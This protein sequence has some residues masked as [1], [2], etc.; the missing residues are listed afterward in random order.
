MAYYR[1]ELTFEQGRAGWSELYYTNADDEATLEERVA[2]LVVSRGALLEVP[3]VM[4]F[5]R[6]SEAGAPGIARSYTC[7]QGTFYPYAP[8][9]HFGAASPAF[10]NMR[11]LIRK[12]NLISSISGPLW[13]GGLPTWI[14]MNQTDDANYLPWFAVY[15]N[16]FRQTLLDGNWF[17]RFRP[18]RSIATHIPITNIAN[19]IAGVNVIVTTAGAIGVV[20]NDYITFYRLGKTC[21]LD[22]TARVTLTDEAN[23]QFFVDGQLKPN[24]VFNPK[25]Y[26]IKLN[27]DYVRIDFMQDEGP[28]TKKCGRPFKVPVGRRP[29]CRL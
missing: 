9:P 13:L 5:A 2:E 14:A 19:A 11:L 16:V 1:V 29:G 25:S 20:K 15:T 26:F 4:T 8:F 3:N 21:N 18:Q 17:I 7:G 23:K 24:Y 22:H 10:P 28:T 27:W 12:F 6:I